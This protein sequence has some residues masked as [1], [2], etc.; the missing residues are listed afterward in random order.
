MDDKYNGGANVLNEADTMSAEGGMH[1]RDGG[2]AAAAFAAASSA[3]GSAFGHRGEMLPGMADGAGIHAS[4]INVASFQNFNQRGDGGR[5][6]NGGGRRMPPESYTCNRCGTKG[7][8]IEDCPTKDQQGQQSFGQSFN[9][10]ARK[11][12]PDGYLCKRCNTPGHYISD[13]TQPKVPPASY[14]CHK[15]RQKGH[16]KQDC[17]MDGAGMVAATAAAAIAAAHAAAAKMGARPPVG[18]LMPPPPRPSMLGGA[19]PRPPMMSLPPG[20]APPRPPMMGMPPGGA[21]SPRPPPPG[22]FGGLM[23]P[24]RGPPPPPHMRVGI[25]R[26]REDDGGRQGWPQG[27]P[28]IAGGM[29]PPDLKRPNVGPGSGGGDAGASE[30]RDPRRRM[31]NP[32]PF[33]PRR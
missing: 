3:G 8:W 33:N 30:S 5:G 4:A 27:A 7:H 1:A 21:P 17:P 22:S 16:W 6:F 13:C 19:P 20:G 11:V 23:P 24:P 12:P 29:M 18:G 25:K 28:P 31:G 10:G 2:A 26:E 32:P 9:G 14:T 15:C